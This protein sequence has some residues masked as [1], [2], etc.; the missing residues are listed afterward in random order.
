MYKGIFNLLLLSLL[1]MS[2]SCKAN[3]AGDTYTIETSM[4]NIRIKLYDNTPLHKANFEKQVEAQAYDST[5]FH[6]VINAF[7]IQGGNPITKPIE[8][9]LASNIDENAELIPGEFVSENIHKKG[10]LA[11][12]R[13][14]D[15][16]NPEK[17]SDA[18][19][20]YIVQGR[21]FSDEEL[22][23]MEDF[24]GKYWTPAQKET[25]KSLGGTPFLDKD[26]TVFGEVVEG[27]G[28]V[29]QIAAVAT[30]AGDKPIE[31]IY[32]IRITKD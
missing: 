11:A 4:G 32:I 20:F 30:G 28:V 5:L 16:V 14:G 13:M 27:L 29:D 9:R 31:D 12:A 17:K 8:Q 3:D 19:Q 22:R 24:G 15:P 6:R 21:T 23:N 26:Y 7:M 10:A 18:Y 2:T 1:F 25:Y